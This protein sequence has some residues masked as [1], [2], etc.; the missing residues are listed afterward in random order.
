[1]E[2][3]RGVALILALL[4]LSF[5]TVLGGALLTTSR[6]DIW[7]S[8]NYKS[9][10]QSLYIAE[11]GIDQGRETLRTSGQTLA[12]M[13]NQAAGPDSRLLTAD[14]L[15]LIA[16]RPLLE[17]HYEV[18]LQNDHADGLGSPS[19][20]NDVVTLV[21]HGQIGSSWKTMAVTVRKGGF[22]E[23]EAD[24]RL[25]TVNGLE[26][27]VDSISRNATDVYTAATMSGFG[28]PS[29][30]RVV[31]VD[32]NLEL[33][34][35]AGYGL[36]LVRGELTVA[37]EITWNGLILVIGQGVLRWNLG[38]SGT[39]NG[40]TFVARTRAAGGSLLSAPENV[41]FT[42]TDAAEIKAANQSFPYNPIVIREK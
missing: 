39:I 36:L 14:D 11:A 29:D 10:T 37:G 20:S 9:A 24:P 3:N 17:G 27:L 5:L 4:V 26:G 6:I 33:G 41:V 2:K 18:W 16:S 28:S 31:I 13:L 1:V 19:D 32:G 21:S 23:T 25:Q 30:Y 8:D 22:P 42:I 12:Q 35:G 34:P 38:V 15:P 40:G 7:I